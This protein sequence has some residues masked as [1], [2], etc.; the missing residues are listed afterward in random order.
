[1]CTTSVKDR[2]VFENRASLFSLCVGY[3]VSGVMDNSFFLSKGHSRVYV[4]F[5]SQCF[6]MCWMCHEKEIHV[7]VYV[8]V[9]KR[10]GDGIAFQAFL[11]ELREFAL[12]AKSSNL[13]TIFLSVYQSCL[14]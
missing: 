9:H 4:N 13:D 12:C 8:L 2:F 3:F 14:T 10:C 5:A 7:G 1:M 6:R 11:T